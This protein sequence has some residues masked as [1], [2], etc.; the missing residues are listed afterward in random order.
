MANLNND[1]VTEKKILNEQKTTDQGLGL[2]VMGEQK[3]VKRNKMKNKV[4]DQGLQ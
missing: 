1:I 2:T 4:T 3:K